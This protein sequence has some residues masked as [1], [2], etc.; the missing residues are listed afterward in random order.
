MSVNNFCPQCGHALERRP[1][2]DHRI[3]PV[4][5]SC[6]F[7]VYLNPP[8]A[9]GVVA[10][11]ESGRVVLVRR[12]ENPGKG[13]WGL[14]AGYMEIDETTEAT[15]RRECL[16]ETGLAVELQE[17]WGVWSYFH[18][19]K[20]SSGVLILYR[21]RISGGA[22]TAGSDS[23]EVQFFAPDQ[24]PYDELAFETHHEALSRWQATGG[25]SQDTSGRQITRGK[26][27]VE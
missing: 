3:R 19:Y 26:T 22:A 4:C 1:V 5:P 20:Q 2:E 27:Y 7:I 25:R 8:I 9:V 13:L 24:I 6:G 12:G 23:T 11:D 15:A 17:L 18:T 10:A 21:A 14:P 16:E